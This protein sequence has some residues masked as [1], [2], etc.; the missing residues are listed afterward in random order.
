MDAGDKKDRK[1]SSSA[2]LVVAAAAAVFVLL[3]LL[4]VGAV[5]PLIWLNDREYL[6]IDDESVIARAYSPLGWAAEKCR[7][8]QITLDGYA[9]LWRSATPS[10]QLHAY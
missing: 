8:L 10:Q 6:H 2:A 1:E 9:E 5:G 7:P 4:Y 3:P